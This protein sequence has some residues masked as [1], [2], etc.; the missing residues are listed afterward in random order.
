MLISEEHASYTLWTSVV[1]YGVAV[2]VVG[3]AAGLTLLLPPVAEGTPFLFFFAAVMLSAWYGGLGPALLTIILAAA[4][5]NYFMLPPLHS[6]QV[7]APADMLRLS[8]FLLVAFLISLLQARQQGATMAERVQR[9]YLQV[10]L[11][12]IGDAVIV[13]DAQGNVTAMNP[14]AQ[15]L[16]GWTLDAAQGKPL[17][18]VFPISMKRPDNRWRIRWPKCYAR[19]RWP[20]SQITPSSDQRGHGDSY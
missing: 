9:E 10:T 3:L 18:E 13:T 4:W 7:G 14:V 11:A 15:R 5:S 1:R 20:G 2:L 16:T 19:A 12:S 6:L 17:A 8:L